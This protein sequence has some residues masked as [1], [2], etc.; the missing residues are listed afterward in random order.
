MKGITKMHAFI[1]VV[2]IFSGCINCP[3][4]GTVVTN[5]VT[6]TIGTNF[7]A[8]AAMSNGVLVVTATAPSNQVTAVS[9]AIGTNSTPSQVIL[10]TP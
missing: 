7:L 5:T 3:P 9:A 4:A 6:L 1:A 10:T 8:S 2:L